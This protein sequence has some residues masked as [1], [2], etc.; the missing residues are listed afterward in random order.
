MQ[1]WDRKNIVRDE[2]KGNDQLRFQMNHHM[3]LAHAIASKLVH[4]LVPGSKVG[5][6]LG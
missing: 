2:L 3:N 1:F 6:A 4:E 5:A